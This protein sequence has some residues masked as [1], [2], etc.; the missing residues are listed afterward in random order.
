MYHATGI[1]EF[2]D[3]FPPYL[4]LSKYK[5]QIRIYQPGK[6]PYSLLATSVI[7][8][9]LLKNERQRPTRTNKNKH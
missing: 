5:L 6:D 9:T 4:P 7:T 3:D 8:V 1:G 2:E